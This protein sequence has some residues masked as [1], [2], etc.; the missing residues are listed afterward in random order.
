MRA[1]GMASSKCQ[2]RVCIHTEAVEDEARALTDL[3]AGIIGKSSDLHAMGGAA[4]ARGTAFVVVS[5]WLTVAGTAG[6]L[7]C[8]ALAHEVGSILRCR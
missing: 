2:K 5:T 1:Q 6:K 3:P 4:R 7:D 8:E